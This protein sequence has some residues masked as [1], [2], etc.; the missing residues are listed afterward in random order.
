MIA[1]VREVPIDRPPL[2]RLTAQRRRKTLPIP[3]LSRRPRQAHHFQN[4]RVKIRADDRLITNRAGPTLARPL[5][6]RGHSHPSLIQPALGSPQWQIGGRVGPVEL[7][8]PDNSF[9]V[10][11]VTG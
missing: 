8:V 9:W 2:K 7:I 3:M 5:H 10:P 1:V 6:D 4:A 11:E